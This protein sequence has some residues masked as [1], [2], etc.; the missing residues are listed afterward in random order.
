MTKAVLRAIGGSVM[1]AVPKPFLSQ[2]NL[3]PGSEVTVAFERGKITLAPVAKPR[4]TLNE[5]LARCNFKRRPSRPDREWQAAAPA[6][7]EL[8]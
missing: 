8:L 6:G 1:V 2:A 3:R 7:Q 5:L 4:Y